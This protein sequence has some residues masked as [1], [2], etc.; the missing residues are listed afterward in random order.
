ML[1]VIIDIAFIVKIGYCTSLLRKHELVGAI[2]TLQNMWCS[3]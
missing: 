3:G 2:I 1:H